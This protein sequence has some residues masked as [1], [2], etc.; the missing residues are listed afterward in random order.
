[1]GYAPNSGNALRTALSRFNEAMLIE[2]GMLIAVESRE[3]YDRFRDRLML[4]IHDAR[5]RIIAFGGRILDQR[6]GVAKYLNSPD[7]PLFDKG[8]TLYNLHRATLPARQ[9]GQMMV[10]EGYLDVVALADAGIDAV[11]AP[12]GTAVTEMQLEM[13]WRQGEC[14]VVCFDGDRAGQRATL[15]A[16]ERALPLLRPARS[17]AIVRLPKDTDPD[18]YIGRYGR[19]AFQQLLSDAEPL[20]ETLWRME[21]DA[22]PLSTP[23]EKAGLKARLI[24]HADR[25]EHSDIRALYRRELLAR[26][27][28]FAFPK[29]EWDR[30]RARFAAVP[31]V[32][33]SQQTR[34][35]L[36]RIASGQ[37]RDKLYVAILFGLL[38]YPGELA[39]HEERLLAYCAKDTQRRSWL[40]TIVTATETL[41]R[42]DTLPISSDSGLP[43]PPDKHRYTFLR[44]GSDPDRAREDLAEAVALLVERPALELAIS[45]ATDRFDVDPEGAF[46]EQQR[47]LAKKR[48]FERRFGRI[49]NS[50]AG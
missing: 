7:T 47:L 23:E 13:L 28:A 5:G 10:V 22:A 37:D 31:G 8:R 33:M 24:A 3:P 4:P 34:Q 39:R 30:T 16:I 26:F 43:P 21:R 2:T 11:V 45:A 18:D 32:Q 19:A 17:L 27:S 1:M 20:V 36:D 14:P 46:A 41:E 38:H 35:R 48:E 49:V 15:R 12:L 25:I 44:E 29:K 40:E 6:E 9:S 42:R 50:A